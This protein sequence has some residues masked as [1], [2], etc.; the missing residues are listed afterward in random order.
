MRRL[1]IIVLRIV[2]S[3]I[4]RNSSTKGTEKKRQ[5]SLLRELTRLNTEI[6]TKQI[7]TG[8]L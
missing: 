7:H 8:V 6:T 1:K 4:N 5:E 3:V 2:D